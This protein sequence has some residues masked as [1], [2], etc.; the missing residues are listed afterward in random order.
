MVNFYSPNVNIDIKPF[1]VKTIRNSLIES[2]SSDNYKLAGFQHQLEEDEI[3]KITSSAINF[4][5]KFNFEEACNNL[6]NKPINNYYLKV[7][8]K[9]PLLWNVVYKTA[10]SKS[11]EL[12]FNQISIVKANWYLR[13]HHIQQNF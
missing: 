11:L 1:V 12:Y 2:V 4:F 8:K 7:I 6:R 13:Y 3:K 10:N 9:Y 5:K